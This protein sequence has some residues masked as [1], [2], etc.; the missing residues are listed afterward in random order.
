MNNGSDFI[1]WTYSHS[2]LPNTLKKE[3]AKLMKARHMEHSD[4]PVHNLNYY[5]KPLKEPEDDEIGLV[6]T[7]ALEKE[8]GKTEL[9]GYATL[10]YRKNS[11]YNQNYSD[12]QIYVKKEKRNKG[13]GTL[14]LN[15]IKE[16]T[17][18]FIT[19][20]NM[21]AEKDSISSEILEK[22]L[23]VKKT[24]ERK[25]YFSVIREL[26]IEDVLEWER[27]V[28]KE[29]ERE[30]LEVIYTDSNTF[31]EFENEYAQ[32]ME[33]I[34][35]SGS[36][37]EEYEPFPVERLR[38]RM[39]YFTDTLNLFVHILF[40]RKKSDKSLIAL[41]ENILYESNTRVADESIIGALDEYND[42]WIEYA[43]RLKS[44]VLLL[45]STRVTHW[46]SSQLKLDED[47]KLHPNDKIL[48]FR[49]GKT[50][51]VYRIPI[52]QFLY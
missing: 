30:G 8:K 48:G 51:N 5:L 25:H 2:D 32:L 13:F 16:E 12:L 33:V 40:I 34:W 18:D 35:N 52:K 7:L 20:I 27:E 47:H 3:L 42:R 29:L 39:Q 4:M 11:G 6:Y 38:G 28:T 49:I 37:A 36:T 44:L 17:P 14:L 45:Q 50:F 22:K 15:E 19:T 21:F 46:E 24:F 10:E 1:I 31:H 23:Q 41:A 9:I 43:L 26:S